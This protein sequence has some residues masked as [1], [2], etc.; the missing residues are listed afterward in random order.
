M[1]RNIAEAYNREISSMQTFIKHLTSMISVNQKRI[2][3]ITF[4][5][6]TSVYKPVYIPD[7]NFGINLRIKTGITINYFLFQKGWQFI[8]FLV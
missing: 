7:D 1:F 2:F 6:N 4:N 8:T 3:I 5:Y